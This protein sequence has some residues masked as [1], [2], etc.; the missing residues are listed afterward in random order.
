MSVYIGL[1][2]YP[3]LNKAQERVSASIS[4]LDIHDIARAAKTYG[5]KSYYIIHPE[6]GQ[7][8]LLETIRAF[9]E[10]PELPYNPMRSEALKIIKQ[11]DTIE[12]TIN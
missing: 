7:K 1:V 5:A 2:H 8:S 11:C 12:D 6:P 10:N 3:V 9:W 4:N